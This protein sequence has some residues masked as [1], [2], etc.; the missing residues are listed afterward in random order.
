MMS[1]QYFHRFLKAY[2]LVFGASNHTYS[3]KIEVSFISI[4]GKFKRIS[5]IQ[6]IDLLAEISSVAYPE[7]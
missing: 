7:N 2:N 6:F 3:N 4:A 5:F 1:L